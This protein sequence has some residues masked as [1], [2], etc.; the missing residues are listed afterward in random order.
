MA[1]LEAGSA[2]ALF[3]SFVTAC[4]LSKNSLYTLARKISP[5]Y[6]HVRN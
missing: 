2:P 6:R 5:H 4:E 3:S 1:G